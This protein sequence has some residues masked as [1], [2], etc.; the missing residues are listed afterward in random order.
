MDDRIRKIADK[1]EVDPDLIQALVE[2]E[3]TKVH[4]ERRRGAKDEI[5]RLIEKS[6]ERQSQ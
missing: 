6:I 4:L 1:H 5:R 3:K 2:Y